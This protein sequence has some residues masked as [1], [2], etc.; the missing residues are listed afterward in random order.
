MLTKLKRK[1]DELGLSTDPNK[2]AMSYDAAKNENVR[3]I[4][5]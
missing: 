5:A 1:L 3:H 4:G 2:L